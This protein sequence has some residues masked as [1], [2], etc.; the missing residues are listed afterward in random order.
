MFTITHQSQFSIALAY[1]MPLNFIIFN[2]I[3]PIESP[4]RKESKELFELQC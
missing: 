2:K 1:L 3:I 4:K